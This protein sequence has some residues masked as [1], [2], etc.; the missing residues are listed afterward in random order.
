MVP[1]LTGTLWAWADGGRFGT[2]WL[3]GKQKTQISSFEC[4]ETADAL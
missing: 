2:G 3:G 4:G 1:L